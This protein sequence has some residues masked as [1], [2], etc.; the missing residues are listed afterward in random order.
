[1]TADE[2]RA[3][4]WPSR[5]ELMRE[6]AA[7]LAEQNAYAREMTE[8]SRKRFLRR[9]KYHRRSRI[10]REANYGDEK[11]ILPPDTIVC[12][13]TLAAGPKYGMVC[14]GC[15][16]VHPIPDEEAERLIAEVHATTGKPQ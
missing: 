10:P 8:M 12:V 16:M 1:M 4:E 6:I 13:M 9:E 5:N 11:A 3:M 15:G 7:Q 2:I 14:G